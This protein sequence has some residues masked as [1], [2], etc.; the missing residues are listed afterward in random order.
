MN[1]KPF[2]QQTLVQTKE[3]KN[4]VRY[5]A[6]GDDAQRTASIPSIYVRKSVLAN[7]FGKFPQSVTITVE[8][9]NA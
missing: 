8:D 7:A 2:A 3:T 5:D 6:P 9:A 4:M 1:I